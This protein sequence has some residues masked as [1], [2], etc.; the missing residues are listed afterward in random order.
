[1]TQL[2]V[3]LRR[4]I[5]EGVVT[6]TGI[7]NRMYTG[8]MDKLILFED[9]IK[10]LRTEKFIIPKREF[11]VVG[12]GVKVY[13]TILYERVSN[14]FMS[15]TVGAKKDKLVLNNTDPIRTAVQKTAKLTER[16]KMILSETDPIDADKSTTAAPEKDALILD[17]GCEIRSE[18]SAAP[19][20]DTM[21]LDSISDAVSAKDILLSN[22][23]AVLFLAESKLRAQ[24]T[25][26][27][28]L[29]DMDGLTLGDFDDMT[30]EDVDYIVI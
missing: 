14:I 26:L 21:I 6:V 10:S 22:E 30:I 25:R 9:K 16:D 11:T 3:V 17:E 15:K 29:G 27:R 7:A 2:T 19:E 28:K 8:A 23:G 24:I 18:K 13:G 20:K 12:S 4:R 1:M 5:F